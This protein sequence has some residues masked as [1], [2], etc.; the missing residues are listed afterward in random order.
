VVPSERERIVGGGDWNEGLVPGGIK[1]PGNK[2]GNDTREGGALPNATVKLCLAG[3]I[4]GVDIDCDVVERFSYPFNVADR[5]EVEKE[6]GKQLEFRGYA[7]KVFFFILINVGNEGGVLLVKVFKNEQVIEG[8]VSAC[9]AR[10]ICGN[11]VI[12]NVQMFN[13]GREMR[14]NYG[15]KVRIK[16]LE[17]GDGA[18]VCGIGFINKSSAS[19]F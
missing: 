9:F 2:V 5:V 18:F 14:A 3:T 13:G 19:G 12:K 4:G 11:S 8:K 6:K 17:N 16:V 15:V 7:I 10:T 1:K